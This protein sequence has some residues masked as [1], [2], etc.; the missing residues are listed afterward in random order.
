MI[1]ISRYQISLEGGIDG[2]NLNGRPFDS[3]TKMVEL[4][5]GEERRG[6]E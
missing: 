4:R 6:E 5:R 2:I 3:S 1:E